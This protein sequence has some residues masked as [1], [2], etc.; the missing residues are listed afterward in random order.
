MRFSDATMPVGIPGGGGAPGPLT[1]PPP[2]SLLASLQAAMAPAPSST[3][4]YTLWGFGLAGLLAVGGYF[5]K[6][7]RT[8]NGLYIGAAGVGVVT[9]AAWVGAGV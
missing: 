4:N 8:K 5:A 6:S 9:A 2:S 3:T 1:Q 7:K